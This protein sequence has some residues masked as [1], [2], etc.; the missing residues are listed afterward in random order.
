ML[1]FVFKVKW[2]RVNLDL[3][4]PEESVIKRESCFH[5]YLKLSG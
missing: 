4:C 2:L 3:I 5:L 1:Y